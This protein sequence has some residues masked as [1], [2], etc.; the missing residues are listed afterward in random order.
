MKFITVRDFRTYP[1][2]IWDEL[3]KIQEMVIT[4]NGKPIALLTPLYNSNFESTIKAVRQAK[5]KLSVDI[6]REIS[7]KKR[8]NKLSSKDIN[9]LIEQTRKNKK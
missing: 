7:I 8:N 6:M 3:E 4:N 1:K 2:K 5:A 9:L